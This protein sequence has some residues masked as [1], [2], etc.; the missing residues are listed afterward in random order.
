ME[1]KA[2]V[3]IEDPIRSTPFTDHFP[4]SDLFDGEKSSLGFMELLGIQNLTPSIFDAMFQVSTPS[5]EPVGPTQ[6]S[7]VAESSEVLNQPTT[8]NSSSISSASNEEQSRAVEEEEEHQKTKK[9]LKPKKGSQKGER[10]P[11][12]AFMTKSE[13]DH[14]E[15]GYRWRKYGQKAVKNSPFPRSYY[16]CTYSSCNVKKR[17]ERCLGDPSIV[18]TTYEGKHTHPSPVMHR[19]TYDVASLGFSASGAAVAYAPRMQVAMPPHDQP[20]LINN[21][22]FQNPTY[23]DYGLLQDIVPSL[24][25]KE[26]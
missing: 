26:D 24:T 23:A 3:K 9:Q 19:P 14:L 6:T 15:D 18:I 21:L 8:P 1:W 16:R 7:T 2:A 12:Y 10:E 17:V 20:Q 25:K 11:R 13:V 4:L 5:I 22:R